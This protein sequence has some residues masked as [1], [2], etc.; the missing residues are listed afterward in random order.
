MGAARQRSTASTLAPAGNYNPT[1][2]ASNAEEAPHAEPRERL[3][4]ELLAVGS[5]LLTT[6]SGA[7]QAAAS[8]LPGMAGVVASWIGEF[9]TAVGAWGALKAYSAFRRRRNEKGKP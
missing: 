7:V 3:S 5:G 8:A 6:A 1:R 2:R 9:G 4:P